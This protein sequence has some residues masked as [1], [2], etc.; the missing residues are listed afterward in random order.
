[1]P[2][3]T[4]GTVYLF[5]VNGTIT[6]ARVQSFSDNSSFGNSTEVKDADGNVVSRRYDDKKNDVS[7]DLIID[8]S[9]SVPVIGTELTYD[10]ATYEITA[11]GKSES[12]TEHRK[13]SIT[14]MKSEYITY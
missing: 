14:A 7:L 11:V 4:K 12:N 1:M 9:Y 2:A 5:G 13:V 6:N 10:G 8:A 3:V